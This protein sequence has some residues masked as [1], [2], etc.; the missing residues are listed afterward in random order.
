MTVDWRR[1]T[2]NGLEVVELATP[3]STCSVALHGA[4]VLSFVP[5]G[6]RDRL[7]VSGKARF[8]VGTALR[9]GIPICFPWF[10]PHPTEP[11][12]A[13]HGFA[14]TRVWRTGGVDETVPGRL[15]A[16][17]ELRDDATTSPSFP[18]PF[19]A[20]HTVTVG[21]DLELRFEVANT[22]DTPFAFETALHTYFAV[23][24]AAAVSIRG[25]GGCGYVDKVARGERHQQ[26]DEPLRIVGEVDRVYDGGGPLTLEDPARAR[27]LRV[28]SEGASS[29]VVWNPGPDKARALGDMDPS[30]FREFVCIETGNVGARRIT[31]P[32]GGRHALSVRY[33]I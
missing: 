5:R 25:L 2:R 28:G 9:G 20:R 12:Q 33:G 27:P 13:A 1:T 26:G 8:G 15:R 11:A 30:G 10:G 17:F 19:E 6:E 7:W 16:L 29:T 14:R 18:H 4:Q 32:P 23:S 24:D 22:G 31:L 21:E 3:A